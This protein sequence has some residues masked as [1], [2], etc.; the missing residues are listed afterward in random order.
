M[1]DTLCFLNSSTVAF[2]QTWSHCPVITARTTGITCARESVA[3]FVSTTR[4]ARYGQMDAVQAWE[5]ALHSFGS[6]A[7][8]FAFFG[9][10][11]HG[12]FDDP[13]K[14]LALSTA[15]A[16]ATPFE[17]HFLDGVPL[18][19]GAV[20]ATKGDLRAWS[21]VV[22]GD[23]LWL[24]LT[25]GDQH[26][27]T[28]PSTLTITVSLPPPSSP[29]P[30]GLHYMTSGSVLRE[31]VSSCDLTTGETHVV[32]QTDNVVTIDTLKLARTT[33]LHVG[34]G[35]DAKC[36]KLADD[37]WLPRPDFNY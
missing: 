20:N 7:T 13:A 5:E 17:D 11:F 14:L 2:F 1:N 32:S 6:G 29:S 9:V 15:T 10:F 37:V 25:P 4:H 33:V 36:A 30:R 19:K 35:A 3:N 21:G 24:V 34:P 27:N 31:P 28:L 8:G 16:L 22:L 12:C 26:G 18:I 23:S